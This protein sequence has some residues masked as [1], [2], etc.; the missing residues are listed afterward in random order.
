MKLAS[1]LVLVGGMVLG[2]GSS[3]P[4]GFGVGG[5][6]MCGEVEP[7]GGDLTGA[8]MFTT[9]CITS[10]GIKDAE[11]GASCAGEAASVT[12]ASSSGTLTF[13]SDMSYTATSLE[14]QAS[15]AFYFPSQCTNGLS[16]SSIA[17]NLQSSS[18]VQSASC[19]G[20][21]SCTCDVV[22]APIGGSETGTYTVSGTTVTL[23]PT[24]GGTSFV[25]GTTG[26]ASYCVQGSTLHAIVTSTKS[27]GS[28]GQAAVDEDTI[29]I[30]Q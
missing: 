22:Q 10:V 29:G 7:C 18:A 9:T 11:G 28:M 6:N 17:T 13:N 8:W 23:T 20:S 2:C 14:T 12:A 27:M 1:C 26:G 15:Y 19:S 16:C 25:T 4:S 24:G 5:A 3:G 21:S 30:K